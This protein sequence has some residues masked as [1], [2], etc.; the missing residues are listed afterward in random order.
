MA[1]K[2]I[3]LAGG[4]GFVGQALAGR[5]IADGYEVI[6]L[7]RGA[8]RGARGT[9]VSW[10]G[11]TPGAWAQSLEDSLAVINLTGKSINCRLTEANRRE[12]VRS[13]VASVQA[14]GEA[15]RR[16]RRPP[17]VFVQ[18]AAVGIY[19]DTGDKVCDESSPP[20]AGF[21]GETCR[22]WE[23]AFDESPTPGVRRVMLRL[24]VVLGREGGAFPPLARLARWFL[25][26]AVGR[27]RQYISWLHLADAV[28]IY[29][30]TIDRE[31]FQGIYVA[32][33]PQ[34][35]TNAHFMR[36]LRAA[37]HRPWSPPV[38]AWAVRL[39]GWLTGINAELA[40]CGQRCA[41]RRLMA[42]GF[43]YEFAEL[44]RAIADLTG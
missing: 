19:G 1:P 25:G 14:V 31:D 26:G 42:Q 41:P 34:P 24:G 3:V 32:A 35:A 21:L 9:I 20:G 29:R 2:R 36:E 8:P 22:Q 28:R 4:S 43:A 18:A 6:V 10:D 23:K 7:S 33:A 11:S 5:L 17:R 38:P 37:V 40:I 15:I 12:I 44:R 39:G 16:C 30:E 27:G 13:R